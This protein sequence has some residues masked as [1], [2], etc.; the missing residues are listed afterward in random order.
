MDW[1]QQSAAAG[2]PLTLRGVP[3]AAYPRQGLPSAL[4][5]AAGGLPL[6]LRSAAAGLPSSSHKAFV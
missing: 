5:G 1:A 6:A 3:P 4:C 2:L